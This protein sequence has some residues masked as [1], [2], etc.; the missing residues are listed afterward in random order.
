MKRKQEYHHHCDKVVIKMTQNE[1]TVSAC[2]DAPFI[3]SINRTTDSDFTFYV[4]CCRWSQRQAE[5]DWNNFNDFSKLTNQV[6][7]TFPHSLSCIGLQALLSSTTTVHVFLYKGIGNCRVITVFDFTFVI[8]HAK[9]TKSYCGSFT[10][11]T[12]QQLVL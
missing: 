4:L 8:S 3:E 5:H 1:N 7:N 10:N 2:L 9:S 6:S 12:K 11:D